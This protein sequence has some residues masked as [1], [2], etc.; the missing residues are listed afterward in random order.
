ML[1]AAFF[2]FSLQLR[3]LTRDPTERTLSGSLTAINAALGV[4]EIC[5]RRSSA[6]YR[7]NAAADRWSCALVRFRSRKRQRALSNYFV[8][9]QKQ[10]LGHLKA[11]S[12]RRFA[13]DHQLIARRSLDGK[14]AGLFS[15]EYSVD[16]ARATPP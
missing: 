8:R 5:K 12:L 13:I 11:D 14:I 7:F 4:S 9:L 15:P 6:L 10:R 1:R 2:F 3:K 16:I